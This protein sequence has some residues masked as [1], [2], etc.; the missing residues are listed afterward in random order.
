MKRISLG[1]I[2]NTGKPKVA[3]VLP[4]FLEWL[5]AEEICFTVASDLEPMIDLKKWNMAPPEEIA[6]KSDF[7]LSFGG[8]GTFLQTA[9]LVAPL[10]VPIFGINMGEFGYLAEVPIEEMRQRVKDLVAGNF[11]E[12]ERMMLQVN[13][14]DDDAGEVH[15]CLN[16]VVIDRGG[17]ARIIRLD[18]R[19]DG[20]YLNTFHADGL[21]I[22]T[23]TGSTGYSLSSGGPILEPCI[24]G[25]IINPISPHML[26][27]RPIVVSDNRLIEIST[28]SHSGTYQVSVDGQKVWELK[29][30]SSLI[31][32]RAPCITRVV[33]FR[34]FSFNKLLR[35]KLHWRDKMHR[36]P[37][38]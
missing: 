37:L 13:I 27:N 17:F 16:D 34:D 15:L 14:K 12:Q 33:I 10:Q 21:I 31:I 7:V 28:F 26:A 19:I 3:E 18:A 9:R 38:A 30:D 11:L 8:D 29:S 32:K 24:P 36:E 25:I 22:S 2:A 1:I 35:D 6:K 20:E 4:E 23:S 5:Y